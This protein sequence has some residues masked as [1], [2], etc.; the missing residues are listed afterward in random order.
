M[1]ARTKNTKNYHNTLLK[2]VDEN[3][4]PKFDRND[5]LD[6]LDKIANKMHGEKT[7][8][9]YLAS[10]LIYQQLCEEMVRLLI[11]CSNLFIQCTV[12]PREFKPKK[13]KKKT[14]GQLIFEM[15]NGVCDEQTKELIRQCKQFNDLRTRI[16]HRITMKPSVK[17]IE[18]QTKSAKRI[19]DH[20][21]KLFA[22]I[23]DRYNI[24][25]NKYD[26]EEMRELLKDY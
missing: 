26:T 6:E 20:V 11:E 13:L 7:V 22:I 18:K 24:T 23:R 16:V 2:R 17:D 9:G 19:Y 21:Y 15:E 25:F 14:F 4:W 3:D 10:F 12:F 5:F 8:T 1:N